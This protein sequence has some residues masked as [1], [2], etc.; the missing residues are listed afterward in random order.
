[1]HYELPTIL[2]NMIADH[3]LPV[4]V[5]VTIANGGAERSMEYDTVSAKFA[6]FGEAEV[7]PRAEKEAN[8]KLTKYPEG[9]MTFGG[10]SGGAVSLTVAWFK[11]EL[12]HRVLT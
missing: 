5:V 9:R 1:M 3:R 12:Y 6:D 10:S 11:P 8:V 7:L 2:D 4:M